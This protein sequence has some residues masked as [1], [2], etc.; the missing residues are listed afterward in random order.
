MNSTE[1]GQRDQLLGLAARELRPVDLRVFTVLLDS[2][3][4][5]PQEF[6]SMTVIAEGAWDEDREGAWEPLQI[7]NN[8]QRAVHEIR[9]IL[10]RDIITSRGPTYRL[11]LP[12]LEL[13][14][15]ADAYGNG[16]GKPAQ[17]TI[18]FDQRV[19]DV[20]LQA[21]SS[22]TL[23]VLWFWGARSVLA[24]REYWDRVD[25]VLQANQRVRILAPSG[26]G[27]VEL[28]TQLIWGANLGSP[29]EFSNRFEGQLQILVSPLVSGA[30][31]GWIDQRD[32][33]SIIE[34]SDLEGAAVSLGKGSAVTA[35]FSSHEA[36]MVRLFG[37]GNSPRP[38]ILLDQFAVA[39]GDS[40]ATLARQLHIRFKESKAST[41]TVIA[42]AD[43]PVFS[44]RRA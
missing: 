1:M 20:L 6:L 4:S 27:A 25:S 21:Q 43:D 35:F 8:V 24:L 16:A 10:G 5:K 14:I 34:I 13:R 18:G 42:A 31:F 23:T 40:Q 12:D 3:L 7:K 39:A 41:L 28:L 36:Q 11:S 38:M 26:Q 19:G 32:A 9:S 2:A 15:L 33:S 29:V 30:G 17:V 37:L 44:G 22:T